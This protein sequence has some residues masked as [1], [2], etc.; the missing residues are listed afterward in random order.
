MRIRLASAAAA[1]LMSAA[2]MTLGEELPL[3]IEIKTLPTVVHNNRVFVVDTPVRNTSKV[4]QVLQTSQ[5]SYGDW[6]W[7][8]NPAGLDVR[9]LK[10]CQP[11]GYHRIHSP[12]FAGQR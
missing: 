10:V 3:R 5:C 6:N 2:S 1:L 8:G 12:N 7:R 4:E 11:G 9:N